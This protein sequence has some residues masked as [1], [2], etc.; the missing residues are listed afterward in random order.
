MSH[1]V[2]LNPDGSWEV[3]EHDETGAK[4]GAPV[5]MTAAQVQAID[6]SPSQIILPSPPME[7]AEKVF[8]AVA[9]YYKKC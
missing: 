3:E 8:K 1:V 7:L 5:T 4:I 2:I 6:H 9:K